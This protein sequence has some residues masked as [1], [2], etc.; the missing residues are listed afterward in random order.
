MSWSL[1]WPLVG[2]SHRVC[3]SLPIVG[4]WTGAHPGF[5]TLMV[6]IGRGK[7]PLQSKSDGSVNCSKISGKICLSV[8][9]CHVWHI[10]WPGLKHKEILPKPLL[11]AGCTHWGKRCCSSFSYCS[12]ST[13]LMDQILWISQYKILH[14]CIFSK[15]GSWLKSSSGWV[16]LPWMCLWHFTSHSHSIWMLMWNTIVSAFLIPQF[17]SV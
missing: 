2:S 8:L 14:Y 15:R 11:W 7:S 12:F 6:L 10:L 16:L 9:L 13:R 3:S 4:L 1:L 5:V 17:L